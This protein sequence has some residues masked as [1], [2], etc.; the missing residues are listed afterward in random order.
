MVFQSYKLTDSILS[1]I[2]AAAYFLFLEICLELVLTSQ[3]VFRKCISGSE[4]DAAF[5][6]YKVNQRSIRNSLGL[7]ELKVYC[8]PAVTLPP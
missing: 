4:F 8:L 2:W 5:H 6:P 7:R 3:K 1:I